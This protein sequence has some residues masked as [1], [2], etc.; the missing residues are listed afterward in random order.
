MYCLLLSFEIQN[1]TL[2]IRYSIPT[3]A[4]GFSEYQ[5]KAPQQVGALNHLNLNPLYLVNLDG[6]FQY[7]FLILGYG[8]LQDPIV[9]SCTYFAGV[10]IFRK[11]K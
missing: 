4:P 8:Y 6:S 3:L 7:F 11:S 9:I 1:L 10:H 5:K 2:E